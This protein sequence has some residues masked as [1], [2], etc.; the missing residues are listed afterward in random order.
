MDVGK[1]LVLALFQTQNFAEARQLLEGFLHQRPK[2]AELNYYYGFTLLS[3]KQPKE[4]AH[5]LNL[6]LQVAV[7]PGG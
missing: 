4:A 2:S 3:L 6:S 5:Y 1:Q 7:P